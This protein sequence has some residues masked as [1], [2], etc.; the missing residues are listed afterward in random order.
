MRELYYGYVSAHDIIDSRLCTR[1][2]ESKNIYF[3][4]YIVYAFTAEKVLL[5]RYHYKGMYHEI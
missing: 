2:W 3:V 1:C 5:A 4:K